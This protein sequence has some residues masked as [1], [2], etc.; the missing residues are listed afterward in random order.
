[1]FFYKY[2]LG[3]LELETV[4][5]FIKDRKTVKKGV[6]WSKKGYFWGYKIEKGSKKGQKH[7]IKRKPYASEKLKVMSRYMKN[8]R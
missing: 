7:S 4:I 3:T 8:Y 1:M 5:F 6:F 2:F